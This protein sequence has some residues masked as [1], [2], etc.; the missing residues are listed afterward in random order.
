MTIIVGRKCRL[1]PLSRSDLSRSLEWRNDP[2]TRNSVL[3]YRFP[4][5]EKMEEGWYDRI[6][7]DQGGKRASFAIDDLSDGVLVGFAHL[8]D[9]DWPCRSAQF[10]IVIGDVAR[11]DRGIGME[12]TQLTLV[13]VDLETLSISSASN[14][15]SSTTTHAPGTST[16]R[17]ASSRRADSGARHSQTA[18]RPMSS[19]WACCAKNF[20]RARRVEKFRCRYIKEVTFAFATRKPVPASRCWSRRAAA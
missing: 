5:T 10:G 3:G 11:Q 7:A 15:G 16:K 8:S 1:R 9:I 19:S 13:Y 18:R 6:L 12:A 20:T 17:W 14:C 4:V 2:A